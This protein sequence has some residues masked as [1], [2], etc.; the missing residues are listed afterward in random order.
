MCQGRCGVRYVFV[1]IELEAAPTSPS[2]ALIT[3][4]QDC[5]D[6]EELVQKTFGP[7]DAPSALIVY[8]GQR[9]AYV[10]A[11]LIHFLRH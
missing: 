5:R 3:T 1:L 4:Q 6:V 7:K 9:A 8:I 10:L 2:S 11:A